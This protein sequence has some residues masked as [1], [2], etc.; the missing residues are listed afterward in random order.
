MPGQRI[1]EVRVEKGHERHVKEAFRRASMKFP[2]PCSV[3]FGNN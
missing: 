3:A 1:L 2:T